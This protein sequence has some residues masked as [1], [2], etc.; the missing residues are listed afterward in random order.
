VP[1]IT[2][3]NFILDGKNLKLEITEYAI[4]AEKEDSYFVKLEGAE[5][6]SHTG[7]Y[8]ALVKIAIDLVDDEVYQQLKPNVK[9]I[10]DE[11]KPK[12]LPD[13]WFVYKTKT[14]I[15]PKISIYTRKN[16]YSYDD[17]PYCVVLLDIV[18]LTFVYLIPFAKPDK[19]HFLSKKS[20]ETY[21]LNF[22][23]MLDGPCE[24]I[25]MTDRIG[26]FA[27]VKEW[28]KKKDCEIIPHEMLMGAQERPKCFV[29]FPPLDLTDIRV[30]SVNIAEKYKTSDINVLN[31]V[32]L[33]IADIKSEFE[34]EIQSDNSILLRCHL[35]INLIESELKVLEVNS[36]VCVMVGHLENIY[37]E[38]YGETSGLFIER[39]L[40]LI[41]KKLEKTYSSIMPLFDFK[42]LPEHFLEMKDIIVH[43][44]EDAEQSIIPKDKTR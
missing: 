42:A 27:H 44:N 17:G 4:V 38:E 40:L 11:M 34:P 10:L 7:I 15:Q 43:P 6:I 9:W 19:G 21:I 5:T 14:I 24:N 13:V 29:D 2:G 39:L 28:V 31:R 26:K 32:R 36:S 33:D 20:S 35:S 37:S 22:I 41:A 30:R 1:T 3:H 16:E 12:A 25:D 23:W 8:R 18:D